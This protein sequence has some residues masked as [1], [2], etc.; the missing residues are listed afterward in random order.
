MMNTRQIL[1]YAALFG[2]ATPA[3]A[4]QSA[5]FSN[6][7]EYRVRL[8]D[9]LYRS[10][11]YRPAQYEFAR[12][13]FYNNSLNQSRK[14]A[15][16]FFTQI[17]GVIL[18]QQ[19]A[20]EGLEAFTREYPNSAYFA[21]ANGPLADYYLAKKDFPNALET[22]KRVNQYQLSRKENTEYVLKLGYAKFMTG[23]DAGAMEAL[24]EAY[25]NAED[26]SDSAYML[27]HLHYA[28]GDNQT[29]FRYFDEVRDNPRFARLVKPY[30]VQM[31]FSER[32]YASA[33]SEGTQL[34]DTDL[35]AEARAELHKIIGE[36]YFM[37]KKYADAYPHLKA[38]VDAK[39]S[40]SEN[41][42]YEMGYVAAQL[43]KYEEA[44]GYYNQLI[45]NNSAL[46][47]NA[48]YQLGNAYLETGRK[49]EALSAFRSASMMSYDASVQRQAHE[50][51]AK[52]SYD[53]GNP[54]ESPSAVIQ[55]YI[56]KYG[57]TAGSTEMRS[58]LVKSYLYSGNYKETLDA[59]KKIGVKS[60]EM[61]KIEQESAFLLGAEEFNKGNFHDAENLFE[62]SLKYNINRETNARAL[63]WMAQ[64]QYKIGDYPSAIESYLKLM[65]SGADFKEKQQLPY[66][67]AY[68]Y[69]KNRNYDLAQKYFKE[70]L[71]NPSAE[72]KADAELR[73][74]DT[75]YANNELS[76]AIALYGNNAEA[77]DYTLFQKA[78]SLGFKGDAD[79]KIAE[80]KNLLNQYKTSEYRDDAQYEIATAYA[81][82]E[83]YAES[84]DYLDR[85]IKTAT[86]ADLVARA[87]I[88]R[89]QNFNDQ[90]N[91]TK[92]LTE[93]RNLGNK[94]RGTAYAEK[95]VQAARPMFMKNADM[96]GYQQFAQS[97]GVNLNR[98]DIDELNLT[99][100]Q[101]LYAKR[102]YA[103]AAPYFEKYLTQHPTGENYYQAQYQLGDSYFQTKEYTKA[104]LALQEIA[105]VYN[106]Y[107]ED[108][109]VR[110]AQIYQ[111]QNNKTEAEKYLKSV[112]N[113]QNTSIRSY[114][115][116]ELMRIYAD[117]NRLSEAEKLADEIL[118][119]PSPTAGTAEQARLIKARSQMQKGNDN[120]AKTAY[121]A[122]EKS[123]NP[124]V[125]AE[126][127]Y[128]KA[129]YQNKSKAYKSSNETIFR[130]ANN[131]SSEQLWGAR[132]LVLMAQNYSALGDRYQASYTADQ[133]IA[134]YQ[135][136]PEVVAE[137]RAVKNR[138]KK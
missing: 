83:R 109:A 53:I 12:Q 3:F 118:K 130:L 76:E 98:A 89:A 110:I 104:L 137:A 71:R 39:A 73:L 18:Q 72:F 57:N 10:K 9:D 70:Y 11:I 91:T 37:Q 51:Y 27:A 6:Q 128:A 34:L 43:R 82:I 106:D 93:L 31:Y 62:Q 136:Y 58:L 64:S 36:S 87:E 66:D 96:N 22:L 92:A 74:A 100:G 121:A 132:A 112:A 116:N 38:Y 80:L 120:A 54:F 131:Y 85:V 19:H 133:I 50:Q 65:Q 23:D 103:K 5:F 138:I 46:A 127:L 119:N 113:S 123:G 26:K 47:Q 124:T 48:Y 55:A 17:I 105:A 126:A 60:G 97:V 4:Q 78:M 111:A 41:D 45:N 49:Q 114:A 79:A 44:V 8:A 107:R 21:L 28:Q 122:L 81:V 88:Y 16:L 134:N 115:Q 24:Q 67:L 68:A 86:D 56:T 32:D 20:E 1:F 108:A 69:F 13:Y 59:L 125:A 2:T 30:Y 25:N 117:T 40:P 35:S 135:E 15:S 101:Q 99:A 102:E 94:Y 7:E 52:L 77:S 84:N 14:E 61:Q 75:H 95:I 63:Y 29:A 33:V 129:F 42:L 90:G